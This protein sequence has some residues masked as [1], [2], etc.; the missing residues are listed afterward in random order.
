VTDSEVVC[1]AIPT[2]WLGVM[3]AS[4]C[5]RHTANNSFLVVY[6]YPFSHVET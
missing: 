4:W 5:C 3:G 1:L 2:V 6:E